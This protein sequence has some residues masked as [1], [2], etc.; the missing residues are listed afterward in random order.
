LAHIGGRNEAGLDAAGVP[1]GG[2][3]ASEEATGTRALAA[4]RSVSAVGLV[5]ACMSAAFA[6]VRMLI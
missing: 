6:L 4:G 2:C 5:G 1:G 3:R